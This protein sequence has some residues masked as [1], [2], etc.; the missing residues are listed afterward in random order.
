MVCVCGAACGG[1]D[2]C[3]MLAT[4]KSLISYIDE[5]SVPEHAKSF[6]TTLKTV[7]Y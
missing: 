1:S 3:A 6:V 2:A 5:D 7:V 4:L